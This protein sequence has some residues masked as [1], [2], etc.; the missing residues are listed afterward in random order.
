MAEHKWDRVLAYTGCVNTREDEE[1]NDGPV[2]WQYLLKIL[3]IHL[4]IPVKYLIYL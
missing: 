3:S 4:I 2:G 1:E